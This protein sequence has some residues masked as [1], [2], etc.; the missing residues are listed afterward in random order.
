[1]TLEVLK[2]AGSLNDVATLL[3]YKPSS[4]AFVLYH[5]PA[6]Q[7]YTEFEVPKR[8]GTRRRILAPCSRL[9]LLQRRLADL[10]CVVLEE[11]ESEGSRRPLFHGFARKRSIVTNAAV[12]KCRR[13]VLNFDLVDFFPSINF[14]RVRGMLIKD[15]RFQLHPKVATI[16]AQIACHDNILPQGS[17]CSPIIS[18]IV[19]NLLDVR[20]VRYAK[21]HKC[22]YSR[23]ADDI[24]FSTNRKDFP[25]EVAVPVPGSE[26]KWV[27]GQALSQEV[28]RAGFRVNP[29]KTRMQ[30]KC[31]RQ[32]VTGLLV[33][34]KPNIRPEYYRTARSMCNSLFGTGRYFRKVPAALAG[35]SPNEDDI[36]VEF[37]D[38][39][40]LGGILSHIHHVRES[41]D[42]RTPTERKVRPTA[43]R[44]LYR[45]FLFYK[46]F[47]VANKPLLIPEGKTDSIY[48]KAAIQH[49]VAYQPQ[50]GS[51][52]STGFKYVV[53]F[54]NFTP[55]VHS[56]LQLG[57]GSGDLFHFI[58]QYQKHLAFYRHCPLPNPVIVL[59]DNDDGA[60]EI[61]ACARKIG[62]PKISLK[63]TEPFYRLIA[64]LYLIKTPEYTAESGPK[65]C[66][67]DFFDRELLEIE[68]DGKKF[69]P[70]KKHKEE[71][72][73]G[74]VVFAK[75]VI[76]PRK[77]Q[78]DFSRFSAI[79]DRIVAVLDDFR[80]RSPG[81]GGTKTS[82][83]LELGSINGR[84]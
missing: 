9:S 82:E 67:E 27:L 15:K 48:L 83:P 24:T 36:K 66:I 13:Y 65:S 5:L 6:E 45:R 19:G 64:N 56:V 63:S 55:T 29:S 37:T 41:T 70:E 59:I 50:L 40:P 2:A 74:K 52:E 21:R 69:D 23:Y 43:T 26:Y 72:K 35:G 11:I 62:V 73:Y 18:N 17:P 25:I 84:Q 10:L 47:V 80:M 28:E 20:L 3:G 1:M 34:Q 22:T 77:D 46:N 49:L 54:M 57:N 71:G 51:M 4:L 61:L 32:V 75:R 60:N 76:Q 68:V 81:Q 12:H 31:S 78:I 14:G 30:Y 16:L 33:N 58:R 7:K 42:S 38:L 8:D 44:E 79:L 39:A 53:R